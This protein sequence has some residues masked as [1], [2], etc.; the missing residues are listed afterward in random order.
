MHKAAVGICLAAILFV[1][2]TSV[3]AKTWIVNFDGS[4]DVATIQ[5]GV[6][7]A[8]AGD[9]VLLT[10]GVFSGSGNTDVDFKGKSIVVTSASGHSSTTID[11]GGAARA[12]IFDSGEGAGSVVSKLTITGGFHGSFGGAIYCVSASPTI[13]ENIFTGNQSAFRGGAVYCD[14]STAVLIHN[15]FDSNSSGFGGAVWCSGGQALSITDNEF[16]S[17]SANFSGGAIGNRGT[18]TMISTNVFELNTATNDG[19]AIYCEQNSTSM[20]SSNEFFNNT[21]TG[22][23][24]AIAWMTSIITVDFNLFKENSGVLGGAV[25]CNDMASG[26]I[27]RN[28][29]DRNDAS[30][31]SGGAIYCTNI[32]APPISKNIFSNSTNGN[33][34]GTGHDSV[35]LISCCCF[36]NNAGGDL[37]PPGAFDGGGNFIGDPE[38]CGIPGSGNYY[39]Q[40]DSPCTPGNHPNGASCDTIGGMPIA[41]GTT[42][43]KEKTWGAIKD[44][45]KN[46]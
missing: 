23:G 17:N 33:A 37:L 22:N 34:V 4:G 19:G 6:D 29:F 20:I 25:Y 14:T 16:I 8:S 3:S 46:D 15:T 38:Y 41:C 2:V 30:S 12:F 45:Y 27:D 26:G 39:L 13:S 35:P 44:L 31:G 7:A 1:S 5:A 21:A 28:T 40:S 9:T 24:G 11:C 18:G 43:A 42:S 10:S 32:S 36:Y